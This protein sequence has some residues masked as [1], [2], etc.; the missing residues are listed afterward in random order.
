MPEEQHQV[1]LQLSADAEAAGQWAA[2]QTN[3]REFDAM[4]PPNAADLILRPNGLLITHC[5]MWMASR[6]VLPSNQPAIERWGVDQADGEARAR[7]SRTWPGD[8]AVMVNLRP[9]SAP[10]T[11][12]GMHWML[13]L[14]DLVRFQPWNKRR[15]IDG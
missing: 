2:N 6:A 12:D 8:L 14:L 1:A 9:R 4:K 7:A 5:S 11:S 3:I 13:D 10:F 15:G